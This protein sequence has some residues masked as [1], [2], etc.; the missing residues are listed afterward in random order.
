M[1]SIKPIVFLPLLVAGCVT[2]GGAP[3]LLALN[4][5]L[6]PLRDHFNAQ[7]GKPRLIGL[8]SPT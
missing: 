7:R 5:S 8:F 1:T 3:G 6:Q 4:D 2:T